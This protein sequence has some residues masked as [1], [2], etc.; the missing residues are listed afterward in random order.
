MLINPLHGT[1]FFLLQLEFFVTWYCSRSMLDYLLFCFA[2]ETTLTYRRVCSIQSDGP[3][4][5]KSGF[6][7]TFLITRTN[8]S[9]LYGNVRH[10]YSSLWSFGTLVVILNEA[11]SFWRLLPPKLILS[12]F[13]RETH[14]YFIHCSV[15]FDM[16]T[17]L[18]LWGS[19]LATQPLERYRSSHPSFTN[20]NAISPLL[21]QRCNPKK[22]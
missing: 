18:P 9:Y 19:N 17:I 13:G 2:W 8:F 15:L 16:W 3:G 22:P 1:I 14:D 12:C 6:V 7:G 11:Y 5:K 20:Q 4:I 21:K 10:I